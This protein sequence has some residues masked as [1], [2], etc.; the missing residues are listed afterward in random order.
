MKNYGL[1]VDHKE[2]RKAAFAVGFGV[3]MGK[4]VANAVSTVAWTMF[5]KSLVRA[6]KKLA[7]EASEIGN[8]TQSMAHNEPESSDGENVI[9]MGFHK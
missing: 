3:C 1:V 4:E 5:G 2:L 8:S 9:K 7:T 6:A